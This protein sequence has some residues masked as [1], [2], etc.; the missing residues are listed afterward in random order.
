M[1]KDVPYKRNQ[2]SE[3]ISKQVIPLHNYYK[4]KKQNKLDFLLQKT[5]LNYKIITNITC[6]G[7]IA[8]PMKCNIFVMSP[9]VNG[10]G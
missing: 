2:L 7:F 1:P 4:E 5:L 3:I 9:L 6:E 8:I 10:F